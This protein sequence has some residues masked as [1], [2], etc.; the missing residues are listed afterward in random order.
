MTAPPGPSGFEALR[1][2]R[3][4]RR[5]PLQT[6]AALVRAYGDVVRLPLPGRYD[7]ITVAHPDHI[8][9]ILQSHHTA[10][11]KARTYEVL[12]WVLGDGLLTAEGEHWR[13]HR[14]LAQPAFHRRSVEGLADMMV[15]E[16][17]AAVARWKDGEEIDV[18]AEMRDLTLTIV[19]RALVSRDLSGESDRVGGALDVALQYAV[20]RFRSPLGPF[21]QPPTPARARFRGAVADLDDLVRGIIR[22][23]AAAEEPGDDLLG[24][25]MAARDEDTGEGLTEDELRD[26]VLTLIL[27]GHETTAHA[28]AW[29]LWLL[30]QH[31]PA[32]RRLRDEVEHVLGTRTA[33]AADLADLTYTEAVI[34]EGMRLYPPAWVVDREPVEPDEIGGYAVSPG[35]VIM[36][37]LWMAHRHPHVWDHPLAFD[38]DRFLDER[39][40]ARPR[41]AHAPFGAGP[42]Q[43]I[44]AAFAMTEAQLVL[45]TI[46]RDVELSTVPGFP[47]EPQTGITLRPR[48]GIRMVVSR[49]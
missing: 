15:E 45:A 28:L 14:R 38:P 32:A 35:D 47:V 4:L 7:L 13:R 10:Y 22:E 11:A 8:K 19:G 16:A 23:R 33:A 44:G 20:D 25:L 1:W 48:H 30:D 39:A 26:E 12:S 29:T 27:A 42:R 6:Y 34:D 24:M 37:S 3:S 46:V 5:D 17:T 21:V 36:C 18:A 40:E 9:H 31:R 2:L 49:R 43:C 41:L